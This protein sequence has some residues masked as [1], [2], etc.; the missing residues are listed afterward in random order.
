MRI[1]PAELWMNGKFVHY[2][3]K[4]LRWL[5][6]E[7]VVGYCRQRSR[8]ILRWKEKAVDVRWQLRDSIEDMRRGV[9][10]FDEELA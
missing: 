2:D 4:S 10:A 3:P 8:F 5:K 6:L 1:L 9:N 7:D